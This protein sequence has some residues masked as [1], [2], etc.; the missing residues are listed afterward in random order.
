MKPAIDK[1]YPLKVW[2]MSLVVGALFLAI[3]LSLDSA[4]KEDIFT[5]L[6]LIL[7]FTITAICIGSIYSI[8]VLLM[9]DVAY[10]SIVNRLHPFLTKI[11]MALL[12]IGGVTATFFV[13]TGKHKFMDWEFTTCYAL[14]ITL[15]TIIFSVHKR[16]END[17]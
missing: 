4:L 15:S 8:P 5:K 17:T 12:A 13:L 7:A 9:H 3:Y 1:Y 11:I 16:C 14:G 2:A 10:L 6:S